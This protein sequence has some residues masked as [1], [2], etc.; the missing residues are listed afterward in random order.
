ME[1]GFELVEKS[2]YSMKTR[3]WLP[4]VQ[5]VLVLDRLSRPQLD[6]KFPFQTVK[7]CCPVD[8][9]VGKGRS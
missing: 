7:T 3:V 2:T 5:Y 8:T 6:E 1:F 4:F 9:G